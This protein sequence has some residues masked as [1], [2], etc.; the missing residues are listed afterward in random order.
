MTQTDP[1]LERARQH[2]KLTRDFLYHLMT[3][4]FVAVLLVI[5]DLTVETGGN[6]VFGLDWAYWVI[7]FWGLGV[8][9]HGI[10]V[11]FGS[12]RVEKLADEYRH[13][14]LAHR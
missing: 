11:Y 7:L 5:I 14:E 2:V 3:Y 6:T 12:R 8:V 1:A 9:G 4:L 10:S 13:Q